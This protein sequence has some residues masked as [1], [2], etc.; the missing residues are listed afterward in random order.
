MNNELGAVVLKHYSKGDITLDQYRVL[1]GLIKS[2]DV[3]AADKGLRKLLRRKWRGK[4]GKTQK[5]NRPDGV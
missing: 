2:G 4:G 5:A 3:S 1:C